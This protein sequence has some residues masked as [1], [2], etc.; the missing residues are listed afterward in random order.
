[1]TSNIVIPNVDLSILYLQHEDL[2][3]MIWDKPDSLL[4]G[5][6]EMLDYVID[7]YCPEPFQLEIP[8]DSIDNLF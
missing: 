5:L 3:E 8:F 6:V 2:M 7:A 4:W 1:M